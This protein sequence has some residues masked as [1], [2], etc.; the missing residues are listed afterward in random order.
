VDK[1]ALHIVEIA[2]IHRFGSRLNGHV[3]FYVCAVRI[4]VRTVPIKVRRF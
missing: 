3:H 4:T 2:L 1:A